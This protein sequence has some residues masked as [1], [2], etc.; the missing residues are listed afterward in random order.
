MEGG[1]GGR[2]EEVFIPVIQGPPH[3]IKFIL[4]TLIAGKEYKFSTAIFNEYNH[5]GS[6]LVYA[7][8]RPPSNPNLNSSIE[9]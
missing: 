4:D 8:V 2:G 1:K 6:S 5:F 7:P 3:F 9:Y